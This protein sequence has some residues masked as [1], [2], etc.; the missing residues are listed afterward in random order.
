MSKITKITL[1]TLLA[2]AVAV[3]VLAWGQG[4]GRSGGMMGGYNNQDTEDTGGYTR[5][6]MMGG[7]KRGPGYNQQNTLTPEQQTQLNDLHKKFYDETA[8]LR[9][10]MQAKSTE[11]RTALNTAD[12]D[13]DKVK[14][15]HGEMNDLRA[16]ISEIRIGYDLE[17]KKISPD[18]FLHG[19]G[20]FGPGARCCL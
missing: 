19:R 8:E 2:L 4:G 3:P 5:G 6:G 18:G 11:L 12:P 20:S 15:L 14:A 16:K 1:T 7:S 9:N 17:A 10:K 13:A